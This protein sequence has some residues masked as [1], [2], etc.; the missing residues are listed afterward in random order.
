V[1]GLT[2]SHPRSDIC[3]YCERDTLRVEIERLQ[4]QS[5]E[6][7]RLHQ[8]AV[9]HAADSDADRATLRTEVERLRALAI[10]A[11]LRFDA[12]GM[13][14]SAQRIREALEEKP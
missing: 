12:A 10:D 14:V 5:E 4:S 11:C 7:L 6:R 13:I 9:R 3:P 2:H 8:K 1:S